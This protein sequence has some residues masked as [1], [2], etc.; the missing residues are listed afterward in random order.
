MSVMKDTTKI[1]AL[2]S[3]L[4]SLATGC[5]DDTVDPSNPD[6]SASRDGTAEA[7]KPLDAAV[8]DVSVGDALPDAPRS[9]AETDAGTGGG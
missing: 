8:H 5:G 6:A 9:D 4:T 7:S 1:L 2:L 3:L